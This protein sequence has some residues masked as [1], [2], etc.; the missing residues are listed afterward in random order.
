MTGRVDEALLERAREAAGRDAWE[1]AYDLLTESDRSE[2]LDP[3]ALTLLANAAYITARAEEAIAT[4]ERVHA[5]HLQAGDRE[6]AAGAAAQISG[7]MLEAGLFGPSRGWIRRAEA[8]IEDLPDSLVHADLA[9][10]S[11][12]PPFIQGDL[13]GAMEASR[14]AVEI[15]TRLGV[16]GTRAQGLNGQARVL[17]ALGEMDEGMALLDEAAV[18]AVSGELD[19][20]SASFLYCST[21]CAYQGLAEYD[22][23]EEWTKAMDRWTTDHPIGSFRG[24]CRAHRA[25]IMRLRGSWRDAEEEAQRACDEVR[26][27]ARVDVGWPLTELGL[28][29]L[30]MGNLAGA[31]DAYVESI[32]LGWD[33]QPG[34]GM[35]HLAQGDVDRASAEIR[36]ALEHPSEVESWE[37]PPHTDLRRAP[38]YA[39]QVEIA[40]AA[41]DLDRARWAAGELERVAS[42]YG[43]KALRAGAA[44]ARGTVQLA[45]GDLDGAWRSFEDSARSWK[46]IGAPYE[47]ARARLA[48]A[49]VHRAGGRRERALQEV[50][51][52]RSVFERLGA[53]LDVRR[54]LEEGAKLGTGAARAADRRTKVFM[55]TDIVRSTNLVE[56]IGDEAWGHLV[57]WHNEKIAS[58]VA[59]Y[60]GDVV[61][62]MGDGFFVAFDEARSGI[63]C[64]VM[65]QRALDEH[66]REQGFSP[67]VRIGLHRAEAT[68]EGADWTGMGVHV[69]ARIGA[70]AEGEDILVS[71]GTAEDAGF[72]VSAPRPVALKGVAEPVE[73]VAVAWR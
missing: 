8:L 36:E 38:L 43:S 68:A 62:T 5:G 31:E 53:R 70:L 19:P 25:E 59:A 6:A 2:Q 35:V 52:A 46:Q 54:A 44:F 45:E 49:E 1:Q 15:G 17:I 42:L 3:E 71:R 4:W 20:L 57:R 11:I 16:S 69:A 66:R 37:R 9:A 7:L 41:G 51:A 63:E 39:A 21:V 24:F 13:E 55:F 73:V 67:R 10:I 60:G 61:R 48:L 34:L 40:V 18:A 22:R 14:R 12:W 65:I 32:E 28:I 30:R 64:A 58:L 29:R 56:A 23:A 50:R 26:P 33:P 72:D 47:S 27:Y